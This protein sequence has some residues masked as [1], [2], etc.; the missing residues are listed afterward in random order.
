MRV[1]PESGLPIRPGPSAFRLSLATSV[2]ARPF[3]A[4]RARI[5]A[6]VTLLIVLTYL[7]SGVIGH[8]PWKQDEAYTFGMVLHILDT[9][10]WVV[11]TLAGQPFM[12]KPP[13]FYIVAALAASALSDWLSLHDG[14][15][16]AGTFFIG[17]GLFFTAAAARRLYGIAAMARSV[18]IMIGCFGM[19]VHAHEMIT[20]TALFAGFAVAIFGL[21]QATTNRIRGGIALG[22]GVGIGF[23]A[24]GL[25]EPAMLGLA[26]ILLPLIS[27]LWRTRLYAKV[28]GI[29]SLAA[30]PWLLIWPT[31]LYLRNPDAFAAWFWV[32]NFGRFSGT[33]NLGADTEPWYYTRTL[34]WFAFP[35]LPLAALS[36]WQRFRSGSLRSDPGTLLLATIA[37]SMLIVLATAA[38]ARSLY[39]LPLLIPLS[40]LA[41][42]AI[43][44]L[45]AR[46]LRSASLVAALLFLL[47]SL[48]VWAVWIT[49]VWQG[50]PPDVVILRD[51]LPREFPFRF[52]FG[53]FISAVFCTGLWAYSWL[54][55]RSAIIA[56]LRWAAGMTMVWGVA[57]SLLLPW[58]DH[59]KS[60]RAPFST[61]AALI[62]VREC[63]A[64]LG[65][66]EP[67]RGML[68]YFAGIVTSAVNNPDD[69]SCD[70]FLVQTNKSRDR[71][72]AAPPGWS[73]IW[74]GARAGEKQEHF[75]V[76][77]R[78][79]LIEA[80]ALIEDFGSV[81]LPFSIA[82][83]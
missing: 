72:R 6:A 75:T 81:G 42:E 67:Q 8:D 70:Y 64:A 53:F 22:T 15:R 76:Y 59:A 82:D 44:N 74:S 26:C 11:P 14:A 16:L 69:S 78:N 80:S 48:L 32:N 73:P 65:L 13:L 57:M 55:R 3:V 43:N 19:L 54:C 10:D 23:M 36:L 5:P 1:A 9:G 77:A 25:V 20:D 68:H 58:I 2:W 79:E 61:I 40:L 49:G 17:T 45:P 63:V 27:P 71:D 39:A 52:Q 30:L 7:F 51:Y 47:L 31:A 46:V 35:A 29:A 56:P 50:H 38:T 4:T 12:E 66:G 83:Q 37:S 41:G 18:L 28:L 33:A 34:L 60:F 24:K 62:P 21:A